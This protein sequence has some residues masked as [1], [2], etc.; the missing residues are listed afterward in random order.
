M[1]VEW[2][3]TSEDLRSLL[4]ER[5]GVEGMVDL[6]GAEYDEHADMVALNIELSSDDFEHMLRD[7]GPRLGV[8]GV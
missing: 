5:F 3:L 2:G 6:L 4:Q 8:V 1:K 7:R